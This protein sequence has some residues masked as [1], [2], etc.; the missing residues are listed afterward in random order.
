MIGTWVNIGTVLA[1]AALGWAL[2]ARLPESVHK[3]A[4]QAI[5]LFTFWIGVDMAARAPGPLV[6]LLSLVAGAVV[7][8]GL[9]LEQRLNRLVA[10]IHPARGPAADA[11]G[12]RAAVNASLLFLVGPMTVVGAI[13]E[14]LRHDSTLLLTKAAL[15]GLS[16]VALS[17]GLGPG[18]ALAAIPMLFYQGGLTVG[19]AWLGPFFSSER[20][21]AL[22]GVGGLLVIGIGLNL[23]G[24]VR[25]PTANFLPALVAGLLLAGWL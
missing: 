15:D 19:A 14:G 3:T 25:L 11:G 23:T 9:K 24:A 18:V 12:W 16:A 10:R 13:D 22:T 17:A 5:G 4:R 1:G 21:A 7:G 20:I 8:E 2:R 6:A